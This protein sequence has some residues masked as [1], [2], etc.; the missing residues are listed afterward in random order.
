MA[1]MQY[2]APRD[3]TNSFEDLAITFCLTYWYLIFF[4]SFQTADIPSLS[5]DITPSLTSNRLI[6]CLTADI[7]SHLH[8]LAA[9]MS[10]RNSHL[11][12]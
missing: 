11:K 2:A 7:F 10:T 3:H 6:G 8:P 12:P 1:F 9:P 4:L 5:L